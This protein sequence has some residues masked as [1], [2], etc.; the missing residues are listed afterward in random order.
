MISTFL[1]H[2]HIILSKHYMMK[3]LVNCQTKAAINTETAS[4]TRTISTSLRE[5]NNKTYF[6]LYFPGSYKIVL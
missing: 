1:N 6:I 2:I 4:G 5:I 3:C